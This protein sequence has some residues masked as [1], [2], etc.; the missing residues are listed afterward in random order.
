MEVKVV[1]L[2]GGSSGI[3]AAT[4]RLLADAGMKVY[5]ASRRG[6]IDRPQKPSWPALSRPKEGWTP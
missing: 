5:A 4:A 2:T 3:G 6:T 1:L